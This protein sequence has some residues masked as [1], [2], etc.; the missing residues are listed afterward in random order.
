MNQHIEQLARK[1]ATAYS[2][3]EHVRAVALGGSHASG[4]GPDAISDLDLYVYRDGELSLSGRRRIAS[5]HSTEIEVGNTYW[6]DGDE[7][8]AREPTVRV[9]VTFRH[10]PW[11]EGELERVLGRHEPRLGYSTCILYSIQNCVILHDRDGWFQDLKARAS[12]V[13][14]TALRDAIVAKN[15]PVLRNAHSAFSRQIATAAE[16]NDFVSVNHRAAALLAS[17]FDIVI[18]VNQLSH[19]GE[20]RLVQFVQERCASKPDG[21]ADAVASVLA[22]IPL[23]GAD[24]VGEVTRLLDSLDSWLRTLGLLPAFPVR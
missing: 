7:W 3:L 21:F 17:Y 5:D 1:L 12:Q 6:E 8:I 23:G 24:A 9:D 11:I 4:I 10:V 13:Y 20:K 15:H 16:R 18:A 14:P 19:P 2:C 22:A